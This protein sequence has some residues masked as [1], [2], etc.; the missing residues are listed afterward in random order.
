MLAWL[1]LLSTVLAQEI[2]IGLQINR[3]A[4]LATNY[5]QSAE[6]ILVEG[7]GHISRLSQFIAPETHIAFIQAQGV[8]I[9]NAETIDS[10]RELELANWQPSA[11]GTG[12]YLLEYMAK[13]PLT[14]AELI[15]EPDSANTMVAYL[16]RI[17]AYAMGAT[18]QP[19]VVLQS[20]YRKVFLTTGG[21][22]STSGSP[23]V[24]RSLRTDT[25]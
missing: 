16:F 8:R 25:L 10:V 9:F 2:I 19:V 15:A 1:S 20:H 22:I 11:L 13:I 18:G 5:H 12:G 7:Q 23:Q 6:S 3:Y 24:F 4:R 17:T 14:E 21:A